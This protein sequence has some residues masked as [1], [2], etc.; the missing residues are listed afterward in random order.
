MDAVIMKVEMSE[1]HDLEEFFELGRVDLL[2][3]H[4][5]KQSYDKQVVVWDISYMLSSCLHARLVERDCSKQSAKLQ[6]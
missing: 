4:A 2:I 3:L 5:K 1:I 6:L